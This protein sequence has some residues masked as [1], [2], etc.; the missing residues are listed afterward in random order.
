MLQN[1]FDA[2]SKFV[3]ICSGNGLVPSGNKPLLESILI[4]V[5]HMMT[6]GN[7]ELGATE[8]LYMNAVDSEQINFRV[9]SNQRVRLVGSPMHAICI[10]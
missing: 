2:R 4:Y 10:D 1:T 9:L 3:K 6:L 8:R 7:N 5:D